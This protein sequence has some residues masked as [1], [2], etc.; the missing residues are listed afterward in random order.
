MYNRGAAI[1]AVFRDFDAAQKA[2]PGPNL[3]SKGERNYGT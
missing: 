3:I 2:S 1:K